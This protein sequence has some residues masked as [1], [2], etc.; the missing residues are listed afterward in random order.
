METK[1]DAKKAKTGGSAPKTKV[2]DNNGF[3][4]T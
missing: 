1:P 4:F 2:N 3:W